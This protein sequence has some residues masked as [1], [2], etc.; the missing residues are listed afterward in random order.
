MKK[1]EISWILCYIIFQAMGCKD[2][3]EK[4]YQLVVLR[5]I[6]DFDSHGLV[7]WKC[8]SYTSYLLGTYGTRH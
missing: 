3:I 4:V 6:I 5:F 7:M 2:E 1:N 8:L